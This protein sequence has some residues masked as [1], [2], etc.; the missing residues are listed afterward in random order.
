MLGGKL[1]IM[2]T[3]WEGRSARAAQSLETARTW[4]RLNELDR[5]Q[6]ERLAYLLLSGDFARQKQPPSSLRQGLAASWSLGQQ[7]RTTMSVSCYGS[8]HV[9]AG[10]KPFAARGECTHGSECPR[11]HPEQ[12]F[13]P[14]DKVRD[15]NTKDD[16]R[17]AV[18]SSD[19]T[20]SKPRTC[21]QSLDATH[22][23]VGHANRH[24]A[25]L[26][27]IVLGAKRFHLVLQ[28]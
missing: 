10:G 16:Y 20:A 25:N 27:V 18:N 11:Q 12:R 1:A 6:G 14:W 8:S 15:A 26:C 28:V 5:G 19:G 4:R 13:L 3:T 17:S 7:L 21:D 22:A 23:T 9:A 2:S 24:L